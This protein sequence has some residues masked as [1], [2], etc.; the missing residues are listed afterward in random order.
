VNG[1]SGRA[2]SNNLLVCVGNGDARNAHS[3]NIPQ[4]PG[5]QN[6]S[7]VA[8]VMLEQAPCHHAEYAMSYDR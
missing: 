1:C 8:D 6:D 7:S 4:V 3:S 5:T 2:A